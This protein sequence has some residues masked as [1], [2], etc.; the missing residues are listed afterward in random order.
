MENRRRILA[1][2]KNGQVFYQNSEGNINT[3]FLDEEKIAYLMYKQ[4]EQHQ[5]LIDAQAAIKNTH[6]TSNQLKMFQ[7]M[8]KNSTIDYQK[9]LLSTG[10]Q[11]L[12]KNPSINQMINHPKPIDPS[13]YL[14]PHQQHLNNSSA[15][16]E[17][18]RVK[19]ELLGYKKEIELLHE[20][21]K[22][23][24]LIK[25]QKQQQ[26][27]EAEMRHSHQSINFYSELF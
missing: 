15:D 9:W 22:Y 7:N 4:S 11:H 17:L 21:Q 8:P 19:Q 14:K 10:R 16:D 5:Q 18:M 13:H 12:I 20:Q 23:A 6:A 26:Q 27:Y 2:A 24:K 1:A 3:P 25:Q